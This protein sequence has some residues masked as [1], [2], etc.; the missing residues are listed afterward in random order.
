MRGLSDSNLQSMWR[1]ACRIIHGDRCF[2]CGAI[3]TDT[4]HYIR[5]KNLLTKHAWQN[6]YPCCPD[7]HRFLHTKAGE[8]KMV[9]W[10][11]QNGWLEYLHERET[12]S[13]QWFVEHG[14]TKNDYLKQM[15]D[16]LKGIING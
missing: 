10:L 6:G 13:K 1:K 8:K 15:Y 5:R 14:I 3:A 7:C 4:H 12:Q 11:S 2:V 9:D 16:E